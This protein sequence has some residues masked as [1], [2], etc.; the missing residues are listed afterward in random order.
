MAAML[1]NTVARSS[2]SKRSKSAL[3]LI[4][5]F[6]TTFVQESDGVGTWPKFFVVYCYPWLSDKSGK[7]RSANVLVGRRKDV[8]VFG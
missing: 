1:T 7:I 2:G 4:E 8:S 6:N 5:G 3:S